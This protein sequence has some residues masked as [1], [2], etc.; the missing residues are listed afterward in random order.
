MIATDIQQLYE[1]LAVK[2]IQIDDLEKRNKIS[3]KYF[4]FKAKK[5]AQVQ[6]DISSQ[7][8][9]HESDSESD[10]ETKVLPENTQASESMEMSG[11][12]EMTEPM[13]EAINSEGQTFKNKPKDGVLASPNEIIE[14]TKEQENQQKTLILNITL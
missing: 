2:R 14:H 13:N 11:S 4:R 7:N 10:L 8:Q 1:K 5:A 12:V 3:E 9:G 6:I